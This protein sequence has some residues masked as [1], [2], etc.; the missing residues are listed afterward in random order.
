MKWLL[1]CFL[2]LM[3]QMAWA[4]VYEVNVCGQGLIST[5]KAAARK[6]AL[7]QGEVKAVGRVLAAN[8]G[9]A[10]DKGLFQQMLAHYE[11]YLAGPSKI[12]KIEE[13]ANKLLVYCRVS[14]D[15]AL[16]KKE[17]LDQVTKAQN[18]EDKVAVFIQSIDQQG[19]ATL[20]GQAMGRVFTKVFQEKGFQVEAIDVEEQASTSWPIY[21]QAMVAALPIDA[22]YGIIALVKMEP[23]RENAYGQFIIPCSLHLATYY[24]QEDGSKVKLGEF[25]NS[26]EARRVGKEESTSIL[27]SKVA[28]NGS[29]H[30]FEAVLKHLEK[31]KK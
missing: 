19:R 4:Q 2:V 15:D 27:E 5:T 7:A 22:S 26:Y 31:Q 24:Q 18:Y 30:A 10:G 17:L 23:A 12:T 8:L 6:E 29:A 28:Y 3:P 13:K 14:V 9:P 21:E 16:M 25:T 11:K 20:E 1:L